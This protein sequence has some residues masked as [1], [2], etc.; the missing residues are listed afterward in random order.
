MKDDLS[1]NELRRLETLFPRAAAEIRRRRKHKIPPI[2][3][4]LAWAKL[5]ELREK[6]KRM[7]RVGCQANFEKHT[8]PL[9]DAIIEALGEEK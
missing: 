4:Q 3:L 2:L 5:D 1:P 7:A 6:E 9:M 8:R